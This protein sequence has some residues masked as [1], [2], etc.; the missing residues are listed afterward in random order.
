MIPLP[1]AKIKFL[2]QFF[3]INLLP[4]VQCF[5]DD[6]NAMEGG[7][8]RE[9]ESSFKWVVERGEVREQR[10]LPHLLGIIALCVE[11]RMFLPQDFRR[12]PEVCAARL[13]GGWGRTK[14]NKKNAVRCGQR[15]FV[16]EKKKEQ[17]ELL[18]RGYS[19]GD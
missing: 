10:D 14:G 7:R 11:K 5:I 17:R 9:K 13:P 15:F 19:I 3:G 4:V 12:G 8:E 2:R 18:F 1:F 16:G 6:V